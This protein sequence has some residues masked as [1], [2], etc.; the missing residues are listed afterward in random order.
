MEESKKCIYCN[1]NMIYGP[2]TQILY[3]S[4]NKSVKIIRYGWR[5]PM[6]EDDCDIVFDKK[7]SN[8]K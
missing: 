6:E 1:K 3:D 2:Q 8:K 5:C 7:D 4:I